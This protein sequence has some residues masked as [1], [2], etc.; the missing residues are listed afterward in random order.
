[1]MGTNEAKSE[2]EIF[3]QK[4]EYY[5]KIV[6]VFSTENPDPVMRQVSDGRSSI[7]EEDH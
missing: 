3:E 6:K 4:G 7:R 5:G 1:M 2:V